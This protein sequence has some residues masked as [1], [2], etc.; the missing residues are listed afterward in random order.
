VRTATSEQIRKAYR[1]LAREL[2][3]DK[4]SINGILY[5]HRDWFVRVGETPPLWSGARMVE[6]QPTVIGQT[7][8]CPTLTVCQAELRIS[9]RRD[10]LDGD[11]LCSLN[12]TIVRVMHRMGP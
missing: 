12:R 10:S 5:S 6:T 8:A 4:S 3:V 9:R 1:T 2:G 7:G 11:Q